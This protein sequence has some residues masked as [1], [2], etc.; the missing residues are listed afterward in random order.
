LEV[1]GKL[2]IGS[3]QQE[4]NIDGTTRVVVPGQ[5]PVVTAGGLLTQRTNIGHFDDDTFAVIPELGVTL[6][7]RFTRCFKARLGYHFIQLNDVVRAG[8]QID[9]TLNL[10]QASGDPLVG[11]AR[12]AFVLRESQAWAQGLSVGLEY[13]Y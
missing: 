3:M 10:S 9:T 6:G 2:S 12:P 4:V 7:Y 13:N 1:L 5:N 8:E 11:D